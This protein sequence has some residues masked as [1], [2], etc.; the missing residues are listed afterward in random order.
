MLFEHKL[1][2]T[3]KEFEV[4]E[5]EC[6]TNDEYVTFWNAH[7]NTLWWHSKVYLINKNSN[8]RKI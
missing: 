5:S 6:N 8:K 1:N 4:G 2:L 3:T 7:F